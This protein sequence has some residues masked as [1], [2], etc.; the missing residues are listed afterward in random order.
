MPQYK[1]GHVERLT[2]LR[3]VLIEEFPHLYMAGAGFEGVGLPDC[4]N[5]GVAYAKKIAKKTT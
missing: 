3:E 1:V 5:Q 2:R 4:V